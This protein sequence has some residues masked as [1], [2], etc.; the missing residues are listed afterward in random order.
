LLR[1]LGRLSVDAATVVLPPAWDLYES[2]F[3]TEIV[4]R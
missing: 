2:T 3:N 1:T 4:V